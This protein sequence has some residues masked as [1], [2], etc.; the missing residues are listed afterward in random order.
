MTNEE[1]KKIKDEYKRIKDLLQEQK[2]LNM[3][4]KTRKDLYENL[5]RVAWRLEDVSDELFWNR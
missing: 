5:Q 2:E 4:L 1:L 3:T